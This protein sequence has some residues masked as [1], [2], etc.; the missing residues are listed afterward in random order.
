[1]KKILCQILF[2]LAGVRFAVSTVSAVVARNST[3]GTSAAPVKITTT[4]TYIPASYSPPVTASQASLPLPGQ[5]I[6]LVIGILIIVIALVG[7]IWRY[8]HPKYVPPE[9]KKKES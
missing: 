8:L 6:L 7:L 2:C 9:E 4:I 3:A 5:E 1:M